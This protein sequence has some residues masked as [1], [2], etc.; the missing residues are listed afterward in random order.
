MDK[1]VSSYFLFLIVYMMVDLVWVVGARSLHVQMIESV[2]KAP[3]KANLIAAFMFYLIAPIAFIVFIEPHSANVKSAINLA[4]I[5]GG[6]MSGAFDLTNK[7]IF[8]DFSW[9]YTVMDTFWG[10]FNMAF[11][12]MIV[13]SILHKNKGILKIFQMK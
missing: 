2:Q 13:Y 5:I 4:L 9:S 11:S 8:K 7:T 6:L 12:S 1:R 10:M 3:L